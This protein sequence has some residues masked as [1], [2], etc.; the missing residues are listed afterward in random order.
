MPGKVFKC[1][2]F[3]GSDRIATELLVLLHFIVRTLFFFFNLFHSFCN[4]QLRMDT[5]RLI[6]EF[7]FLPRRNKHPAVGADKPMGM[8]CVLL[9]SLGS[10]WLSCSLS[11][12]SRYR[13]DTT[14]ENKWSPA[15][16]VSLQRKND[17]FDY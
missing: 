10:A 9:R 16:D 3:Y 7:F 11:E 17:V 12:P 2:S 13:Q 5:S 15:L 14:G 6:S 4:E 8:N 1:D